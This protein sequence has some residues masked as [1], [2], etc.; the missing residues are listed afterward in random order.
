[1]SERAHGFLTLAKTHA[2]DLGEGL[3]ELVRQVDAIVANN[4]SFPEWAEHDDAP[5]T[6]R[7]PSL[8]RAR[9]VTSGTL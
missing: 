7:R 1:L 8:T 4:A 3:V 9:V 2:G 5:K 6:R